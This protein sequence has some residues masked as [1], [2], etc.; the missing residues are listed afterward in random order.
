[1]LFTEFVESR[2]FANFAT[3][4]DNSISKEKRKYCRISSLY[5]AD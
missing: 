3:N 2:K 1:M 4:Y 5:V